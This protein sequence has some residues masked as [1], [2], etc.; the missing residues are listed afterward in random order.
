MEYNNCSF[1]YLYT[2][3][4]AVIS[5]VFEFWDDEKYK[6]YPTEIKMIWRIMDKQDFIGVINEAEK[7]GA[8]KLSLDKLIKKQGLKK[9]EVYKK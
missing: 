8:N 7:M 5:N 9:N 2:N 1:F 4:D 3:G 6:E